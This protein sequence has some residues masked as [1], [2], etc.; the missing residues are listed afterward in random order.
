LGK[1]GLGNFILLLWGRKEFGVNPGVFWKGL[2]FQPTKGDLWGLIFI[3]TPLG[4]TFPF[5]GKKGFRNPFFL[6]NLKFSLG[7]L[8][9][10][11]F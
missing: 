7:I 1:L 5:L 10:L 6:K 8:G 4:L 9:Q 3:L 2:F 11:T